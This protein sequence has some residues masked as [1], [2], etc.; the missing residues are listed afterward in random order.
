MNRTFYTTGHSIYIGHFIQQDIIYKQDILQTE[1][2]VDNTFTDRFIDKIFMQTNYINKFNQIREFKEFEPRL[3]FKPRLKY[4]WFHLK[5]YLIFQDLSQ[6][7]IENRFLE[8]LRRGL[9]SLNS[10]FDVSTTLPH[11]INFTVFSHFSH[12]MF[13]PISRTPCFLPFLAIHVGI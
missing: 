1:N 6:R 7:S 9:N 5:L 12:S 11:F 2:F 4:G 13:S 10:D 3:Y 8:D